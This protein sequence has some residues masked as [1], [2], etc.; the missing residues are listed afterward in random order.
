MI[1]YGRNG[2]YLIEA[3][4]S[5]LSLRSLNGDF[6]LL[7]SVRSNVDLNLKISNKIM[8]G[9]ICDSVYSVKLNRK[10]TSRALAGHVNSSVF[11]EDS[12]RRSPSIPLTVKDGKKY[13][14]WAT[15]TDIV[16]RYLKQ[17]LLV[18]DAMWV[19]SDRER[20]LTESVSK[21]AAR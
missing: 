3:E 9:V 17:D 13:W 6:E 12:L 1:N 15:E 11:P 14:R 21:E 4:I 16:K 19:S 18:F 10:L 5:H 8:L 20:G 2:L 7:V